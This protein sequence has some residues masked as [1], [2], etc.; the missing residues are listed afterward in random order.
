[1]IIASIMILF[2]TLM[3]HELGHYIFIKKCQYP[4]EKITFGIGPVLYQ[5]NDQNIKFSIRL[6][7]ICAE[8]ECHMLIEKR[9]RENLKNNLL[10]ILSGVA[11]NFFMSFLGVICLWFQID[12]MVPFANVNTIV[13]LFILIQ[14]MIGMFNLLPLYITDGSLV[15][16]SLLDYFDV[17]GFM[18][19]II[20]H[21]TNIIGIMLFIF[22]ACELF[23]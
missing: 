12:K 18:K 19:K 8:I 9:N 7:P 13:Y 16:E 5:W 21:L 3:F 6:F 11:I 10:I 22:F 2:V 1:M 17:L 23:F 14:M 15:V 20:Y 4:I